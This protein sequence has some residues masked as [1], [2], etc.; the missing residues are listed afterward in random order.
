MN[1][2]LKITRPIKLQA[3]RTKEKI[4]PTDLGIEES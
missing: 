1:P 4:E 2:H 3:L